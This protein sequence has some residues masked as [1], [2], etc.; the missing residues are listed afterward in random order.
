M[1]RRHNKEKFLFKRGYICF[2]IQKK[3][4]GGVNLKKGGLFGCPYKMRG[5]KPFL[6]SLKT[7][8]STLLSS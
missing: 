2:P 4:G 5:H 1:F 3:G 6:H 8:W 7:M